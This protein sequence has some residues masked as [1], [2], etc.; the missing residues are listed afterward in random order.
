MAVGPGVRIGDAEREAVATSLREHYAGGRL[1]HEEF[2]Q[3][4]D[5]VFA[6]KTDVDLAQI[7]RDLPHVTPPWPPSQPAP[8]PGPGYP[9]SSSR[10]YRGRGYRPRSFGFAG[11]ALWLLLIVVLITASWPF[12]GLPRIVLLV[13]AI[14]AFVRRILRWVTGGPRRRWR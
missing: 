7:T 2:Q 10:A 5:A 12:G 3:R 6:A 8:M 11:T 9:P 14:F 1:T 4:L 13:L